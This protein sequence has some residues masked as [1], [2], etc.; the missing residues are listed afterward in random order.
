MGKPLNITLKVVAA[1]V[2]L[3]VVVVLVLLFIVDPNQYKSTIQDVVRENTGLEL[4]IA[5][6]LSLSFQPVGVVLNDVRLRNPSKPQELAS[7]TQISLRVDA[8]SLLSGELLIEELSADDFHV[9]WFVDDQGISIWTTDQDNADPQ[10]PSNSESNESSEE[11]STLTAAINLISIANASIDIQN[12]QQNY[13]YSIQGLDITSRD[14]NVENRPFSIASSFEF[15]DH[16]AP[17]PLPITLSSTNRVNLETGEAQ[18]EELQLSLTPM[19][20]RG[21]IAIQDFNNAITFSGELESNA[22]ALTDFL[23][24]L[25]EEEPTSNF[26]LPGVNE[27]ESEQVQL[28]LSFSG[29]QIQAQ[30]PDLQISLGDTLFEAEANVRFANELSP[31]NISYEIESN[32]LNLNLYLTDD[33][34][35][36][37]DEGTPITGVVNQAS[38]TSR[39]SEFEIPTS[40]MSGVNVQGTISIESLLY[41]DFQFDDIDLFTNLENGVLDIESQSTNVLDGAIQ[42]NIRVNSLPED[43]EVS[44]QLTGTDINVADLTL[45]VVNLDTV[46]G[47]LNL[48]VDYSGQGNTLTELQNSLD[49][50]A[51]FTVVDNTVDIGIIKQV[52]TAIAALSPSGEAIQ[53]WP[54]VIQFSNFGGYVLFENGIQE[55]QEIKIRLDNFDIE[56]T[57]GLNLE[58]GSFNYDFLFTML[59]EPYL[60]TIPISETYHNVPW[61]VQCNANFTDDVTQFCSPD[62]TQVR[63]LFLQEGVNV[64]RNRLDDVLSDQVPEELQDSARGLLRNLFQN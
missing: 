28:Q 38:E 2:A 12:L 6:D 26:A 54:D 22:F 59:G 5:G 45:S 35:E 36:L 41:K 60:Q 4:N 57:G 55:N 29:D 21:A 46:T 18:I 47:K 43:S 48:E 1:L 23:A 50:S 10:Q 13:Y 49:G 51:S 44:V 39:E 64:I 37:S 52:F 61:P 56:G 31:T 14:S 20:L 8:L 9:N 19:Q 7:S 32:A 11:T 25:A 63:E 24:N 58:E 33:S 27:Q 40:L 42:G 3:V 30:I 62:F 53:Q 16:T 34:A 17:R 15:I